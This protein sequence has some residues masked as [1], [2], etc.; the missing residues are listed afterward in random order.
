MS[1]KINKV[2]KYIGERL[3]IDIPSLNLSG[4]EIIGI[5][6]KNGSGKTT[7]LKMIEGKVPVDEGSIICSD[8]IAVIDQL[9][10]DDNQKSGGEQTK[11]KI[12]ES[13]AEYSDILLADEPTNHLDSAGRSYLIKE[14]NRFKGLV[15]IVSHD[16]DFLNQVCDS[17]L[18]I[19]ESK[20]R[21]YPG[22]Y[23]N[24]LSQ[25]ELEEK[26]YAKK[27]ANYI[28]EK[29]RLEGAAQELHDKSSGIKKAPKRMGNSEARLHKRGKGQLAKKALSKQALAIETRLDKLEIIAT[30]KKEKKLIIPFLEGQIIHKKQVIEATDFNLSI[31]NKPLLVDSQ[32]QIRT[33]KRTALVGN[34][35]VGKTTLLKAIIN[36]HEQLCLSEKAKFAYFSQSFNQ[37]DD[38]LSVLE[39]V[40]KTSIYEPQAARDL[41]AHLL[42]RGDMVNKKVNVLSGGERTKLAIAKMILSKNNVLILDEPTNH[43]D[44]ESLNVLEESLKLYQGTIIFV[45]HD[46][47][48][49]KAVADDILE[50]KNKKIIKPLENN[51]P[52]KREKKKEDKMILE[53][54][55]TSLLSQLSLLSDEEKKG[56]LE[57]ELEEVLSLLKN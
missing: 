56:K 38:S 14:L 23:N 39:N 47:Y 10:S 35:G 46:R 1:I 18:E 7:F 53:M 50:I 54:R 13:L 33:G 28:R 17:I 20:T 41:L 12:R 34:N 43:L 22:N 2:K 48:F 15:L 31:G 55:K 37:L 29:N 44:I 32:F 30:P 40:Q 24:Y 36:K 45:S 25:K 49:I 26:E 16:R 51:R 11:E 42:F 9:L 5:V 3:L 6:G 57:K 27:Y 52:I 19:H 4:K 21:L 8:K